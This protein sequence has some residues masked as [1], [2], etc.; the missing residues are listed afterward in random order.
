MMQ[1]VALAI[2]IAMLVFPGLPALAQVEFSGVTQFARVVEMR[3]QVQG[4]IAEV[5]ASEG[6]DVSAGDLLV[7]LDPGLQRAR[8][9]VARVAAESNAPL[10]RA[11]AEL[12]KSESQLK[13]Y[14]VAA[15]RGG[16]PRW[17]V[18]EA[19]WAVDVS[20]AELAAAEEQERANAARLSLEE[21]ALDQFSLKAPFDGS[22]VEVAARVGALADG[23]EPLIVIADRSAIEIVAFVP[24]IDV[25]L[26]RGEGELIAFLGEP[27]SAELPVK[28]QFV[29]PRID[30]ASGTA[31]AVFEFDNSQLNYP[32]GVQALIRLDS[33]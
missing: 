28:L 1:R 7:M 4:T 5:N 31:R 14:K 13:R 19:E 27:V 8:V 6:A 3:A 21:I 17:E 15:A 22:I 11:K 23:R 16:V 30:P 32:A 33:E 29:D 20:K 10:L 25:E 9:E 18:E 12:K 24:A 2:M 26:L